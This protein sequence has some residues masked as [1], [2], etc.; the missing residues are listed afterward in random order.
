MSSGGEQARLVLASSSPRRRELLARLDVAFDVVPAEIDETPLPGESPAALVARLSAAKAEAV[1]GNLVLGSD[2]VVAIGDL[3]LG[4]PADL[5]EAREMLGL[6][7]D[8]GHHTV[9]TGVAVR[10]GAVTV[11]E[12]GE[13]V[14]HMGPLSDEQIEW[15]L[16]TGDWKGKAGGYA[17]QSLAGLMIK[18]I[19]GHPQTVIGMPTPLVDTLL[20]QHGFRLL[21]FVERRS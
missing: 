2:T 17:I 21:D 16:D 19:D 20:N 10:Y 4:K 15:Y 13:A 18:R 8:A 5:Y 12:V 14:V 3:A 11:A 6:L 1:E 7:S 9:Y